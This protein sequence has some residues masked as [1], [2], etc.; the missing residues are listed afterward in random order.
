MGTQAP[1]DSILFCRCDMS[2]PDAHRVAGGEVIAF[3]SRSPARDSD[4]E[5]AAAV[6]PVNGR[7]GVLAVAD[8]VGGQ[9]CG[10]DAANGALAALAE[11]VEARPSMTDEGLRSALLDGFEL[12]N[13]RVMDL[14]TGA[15]T[16]MAAVELDGPSIRPFHV[17]DSMI[18]VVGQRGKLKHQTLSHS[19]VAYGVA[20]GLLD[21]EEALHHEERHIVSNIVGSPQMSIDVGSPL[22]LA[23]RDTVLL[24]TDG[25]FDNLHV[26]EIIDRL[27][28]GPLDEV[29]ATIAADARQRMEHPGPDD[30]SKPDDMTFLVYRRA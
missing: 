20:A 14:G 17:G 25:L 3:S 12:A 29:A 22:H 26:E 24:A 6:I 4:N 8:G 18:L 19:P 21:P 30:P 7:R 16:T 27:R 1:A 13:R 23:A 15:A 9:P 10:V 28:K 2:V 5:D 11:C